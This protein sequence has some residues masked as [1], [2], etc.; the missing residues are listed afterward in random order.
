MKKSLD[1]LVI[2]VYIRFIFDK[3]VCWY[4]SS[5]Q[6]QDKNLYLLHNFGHWIN[7]LVFPLPTQFAHSYQDQMQVMWFVVNLINWIVAH[8][9]TNVLGISD[10]LL[11]ILHCQ[12]FIW[13]LVLNWFGFNLSQDLSPLEALSCSMWRVTTRRNLKQVDKSSTNKDFDSPGNGFDSLGIPSFF[14]YIDPR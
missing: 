3:Y 11:R 4:F 14:F 13:S 12:K 5:F 9:T 2:L 7:E 1:W 8:F 6:F 10:D